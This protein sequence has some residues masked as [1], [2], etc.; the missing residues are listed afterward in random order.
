MKPVVL[1]NKEI[2]DRST[3]YKT[4]Y[5]DVYINN[6]SKTFGMSLSGGLDSAVIL[7]LLAKTLHDNNSDSVIYPYTARRG[8]P[9]NLI[10]YNRVDIYPYVDKIIDYVKI[11]YPTVKIADSLKKDADYWWIT[12]HKDGRN[13]GSYTETINHL[14]RYLTWNFSGANAVQKHHP[15][16]GELLYVEYSGVTKNP[17][18][19][20]LPQSD[21]S[22]RDVNH[23]NSLK[24]SSATVVFTDPQNPFIVYYEPFRNSD[25]RITLWLANKYGILEDLLPITR[26]CEGGEIETEN[27]TKECMQCWWCLERK[28]ALESYKNE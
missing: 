4:P 9:T 28:W 23:P 13:I 19:G 10:E 18:K 5:G 20:I 25:K 12:E 2:I 11:K 27:F 7:F 15:G 26:S 17:P 8:N 24:D 16:H 14:S 1:N 3:R 21:E 22:H 6:S